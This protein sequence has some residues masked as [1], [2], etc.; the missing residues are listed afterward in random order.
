[1][2]G[3]VEQVRVADEDKV[4]P[5]VSLRGTHRGE[6]MGISPTETEVSVR[7]VEIFR[8]ASGQIDECWGVVDRTGLM[9]QRGALGSRAP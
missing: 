2:L 6:L 1:M 9:K 5:L 8:L 3:A 7:V 4:A